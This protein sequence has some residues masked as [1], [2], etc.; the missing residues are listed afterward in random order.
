MVELIAFASKNKDVDAA[1]ILKL[2][3]SFRQVVSAESAFVLCYLN[4]SSA[5]YSRLVACL[6]ILLRNVLG[7]QF[8]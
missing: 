5:F 3:S 1:E 7:F 2:L 4:F 8:F 6:V